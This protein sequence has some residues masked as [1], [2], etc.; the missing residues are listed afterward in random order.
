MASGQLR[1]ATGA[2][3]LPHDDGGDMFS[4]TLT[5]NRLKPFRNVQHVSAIG[6]QSPLAKGSRRSAAGKAQDGRDDGKRRSKLL[7]SWIHPPFPPAISGVVK[8]LLLLGGGLGFWT[9]GFH[10]SL[11]VSF[12]AALERAAPNSARQRRLKEQCD[13]LWRCMQ[14]QPVF[15]EMLTS[16]G[17]F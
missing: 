7:R 4:L 15:Q 17:F 16:V 9:F 2:E 6:R 10:D 5:W 12:R 8:S 13:F 14:R 11:T 1:Y 3:P